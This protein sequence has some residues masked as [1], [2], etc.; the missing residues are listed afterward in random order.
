MLCLR[1]DLLSVLIY[2]YQTMTLHKHSQVTGSENH[3]TFIC[4]GS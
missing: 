1:T 3:G 2:K 4:A